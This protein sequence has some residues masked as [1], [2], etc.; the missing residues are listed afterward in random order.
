MLYCPTLELSALKVSSHE[1]VLV[2]GVLCGTRACDLSQVA[3]GKQKLSDSVKQAKVLGYTE[4]DPRD[5]LNG[6]D[7]ARMAVIL[8]RLTGLTAFELAQT[9]I[10]SLVP[11]P[12]QMQ[13]RRIFGNLV[14]HNDAMSK[15]GHGGSHGRLSIA[16]RC[17]GV[18]A[19][20]V[21][22]ALLA[23]ERATH[24]ITPGRTTWW[25]SQ[26]ILLHSPIGHPR[27][28]GWWRCHSDRRI[29]DI[30]QCA[31]S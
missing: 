8:G 15:S 19:C 11:M 17:K 6:T 23:C 22:V 7:V 27:S 3:G 1:I 13:H 16:L 5:D 30:L 12:L 21:G 2:E 20:E 25:Q 14:E 26:P 18:K 31:Y 10:E 4:P 28:G 9:E 29:G 24:S